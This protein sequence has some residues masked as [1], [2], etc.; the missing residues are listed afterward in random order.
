MSLRGCPDVANIVRTTGTEDAKTVG[1]TFSISWLPGSAARRMYVGFVSQAKD[2]NEEA[3]PN[4]ARGR[5]C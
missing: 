2:V 1:S 4:M 5:A 3:W